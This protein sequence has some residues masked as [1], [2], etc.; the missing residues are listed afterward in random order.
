MYT[1]QTK[2]RFEQQ[3]KAFRNKDEYMQKEQKT[4]NYKWNMTKEQK[5]IACP[6]LH[7]IKDKINN[8][9]F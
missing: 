4:K 8:M 3:N 1:T 7:I 5:N 9:N 6:H 2:K